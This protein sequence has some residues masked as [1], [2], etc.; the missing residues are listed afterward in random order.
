MK[1]FR[2]AYLVFF[3]IFLYCYEYEEEVIFYSDFSGKIILKYRVPISK[4]TKKSYIYFLPSTKEDF[5][6]FYEIEPIKFN[7]HSQANS[8]YDFGN[9]EVEFDFKNLQSFENKLLGLQNVIKIG[10]TLIIK[11]KLA[12]IT[13][14]SLE[15]KLYSYF[16]EIFYQSV[17]GK[18]LKFT[19]KTPKHYNL[20]SNFG[21]LPYPGVLVFQY[22]LEKT[23][24]PKNTFL[25]LITIKANP[26]P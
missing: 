20:T 22:S 7:F 3:I 4:K 26:F 24:E 1:I 18:N 23:L 13:N 15:N 10:D 14:R 17:K 25:W 6:G 19:I 8:Y 2:K 11:R 5:K 12:S 21:N 16:Y 9:I